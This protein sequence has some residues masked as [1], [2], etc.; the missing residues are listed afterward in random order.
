VLR[1]Y[2]CAE[3]QIA[4]MNW[5]VTSHNHGGCFLGTIID[6][7]VYLL[8]LSV[9]VIHRSAALDK[10]VRQRR[11]GLLTVVKRCSCFSGRASAYNLMTSMAK[12]NRIPGATLEA[13]EHLLQMNAGYEQVLRSAAALCANPAF[14]R[15]QLDLFRNM[16]REARACSNAYLTEVLQRAELEEAGRCF[17]RR[18]RREREEEQSG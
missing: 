11:T 3:N 17:R 8:C 2:R 6:H 4:M 7:Y 9:T 14:H 15:D 13:Y 12:R 1:H 10:Q 18:T 5:A 16:V